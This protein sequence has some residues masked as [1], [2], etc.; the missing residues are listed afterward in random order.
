VGGGWERGVLLVLSGN[1]KKAGN[2]W[3]SRRKGEFRMVRS[4][5]TCRKIGPL[6]ESIL[7]LRLAGTQSR[8]IERR[9][10]VTQISLKKRSRGKKKKKPHHH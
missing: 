3:P 4:I 2:T 7:V 5:K 6:E 10:S 8:V 9:K 1:K